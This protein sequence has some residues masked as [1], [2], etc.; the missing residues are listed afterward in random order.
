M[1]TQMPLE[2]MVSA[3][4]AQEAVVREAANEELV[5]H[6]LSTTGRQRSRPRWLA[7]LKEP[8]MT[9]QAR[10]AV[11]SPTRRLAFAVVLI[12][13]AAVAV[14]G[15]GAAILLRPQPIPDDW[16]GFRG[17]PG[18]TGLAQNGPT[19]NPVIRWRVELGAPVRSDVAVVGD[20]VI[21]PTD[22]GVLHA[23]S[24]VDGHES[25]SYRPGTSMTGPT[26]A[27]GAVYVT[28]GA[29]LVRAIDLAGGTERWRSTTPVDGA[30]SSVAADGAIF[31]GTGDGK[32]ESL[33]L[34]TGIQRWRTTVSTDGQAAGAPAYA[35]GLVFAGTTQGLVAL[36]ASSGD[37]VWRLDLEGDPFGSIVV[38]DG[39]AYV[40]PGAE[41]TV[42]RLRAVDARTGSLLWTVSEPLTSPSVVGSLAVSVGPGGVV[43]AR[44][45]RSG[46]ELWRSRNS[47]VNRA[48]AIANGI[49]YV[50][51]DT[52]RQIYAL[53]AATGKMYWQLGVDGG[54][55][56]CVAVARGLLFAGTTSGSVYAIGG[57]GAALVPQPHAP[58][59]A[60]P[61]ATATVRPSAALPDPF[62][63]GA[64]FSASDLHLNRPIAFA[65]GPTGDVYVTDRSDHVTQIDPNGKVV[66]R[67]GGEGTKAGQFDFNPAGSTDN[68]QGSIAVG[69]DGKV[70]VSD[71]DN[72]RIQVFQADGTFVRQFGS[73]GE[74]V[75]QFTVPFDLNA[76]AKGNVYV[77]DD[78]AQNLQKFD[79]TGKEIW[80]ASRLT[81]PLLDG[82]GHTAAFDPGGRIVV[83][84]DDN[85]QIVYLDPDGK[86][87][88][89][90]AGNG[91]AAT[92]DTAGNVYVDD[93][94]GGH[95]TVFDPAH[96][97]IGTS[98]A[99]IGSPQFGPDGEAVAMA[100][101]GSLVFLTVALPHG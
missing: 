11:G 21:V 48:P 26:V 77:L 36:R 39:I 37:L 51:A 2:R 97:P 59:S 83:S 23:L 93:C 28:D 35:D 70:Y 29:G 67:W 79:P 63:M 52:E 94:G 24:I 50:A 72:H 13:L 68:P 69:L 81:D 61:S 86:V 25:W 101:D 56:C 10:V 45:V 9:A 46:Q 85:G 5:H 33:D 32:I 8:P 31:V 55:Q 65:V 18:H 40:G 30:T 47:G 92:V 41:L 91:C 1:S 90:F 78:G 74:T 53:D 88:D 60:S 3:W 42:G 64:R 57:D 4:M 89:S 84:N 20:L 27:N 96:R 12:L 7:L 44:D 43:A 98:S 19:G 49:V 58:P 17:G 14:I 16:A 54:Q 22:N 99:G 75:G 80:I 71:S 15:V 62:T 38:A 100:T 87:V 76:D 66:R 6:V 82:H 73:F 95:V 34:A